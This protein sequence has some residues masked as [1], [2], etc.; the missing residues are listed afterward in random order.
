MGLWWMD[1]VLDK[2]QMYTLEE[3]GDLTGELGG[4]H[5][6]VGG[7]GVLFL[8]LMSIVDVVI[9]DLCSILLFFFSIIND[10]KF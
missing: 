10:L 6:G 3:G 8:F 9:S 4:M 1:L 2:G 5:M 7:V